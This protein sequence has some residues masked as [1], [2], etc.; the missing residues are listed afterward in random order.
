L[1]P[2]GRIVRLSRECAD[3]LEVSPAEAEGNLFW[4]YFQRKED[5]AAAQAYF[6][7]AKLEAL[8]SRIKETWMTRTHRPIRLE[9]LV[10]KPA[11]DKSGELTHI[12]AVAAPARPRGDEDRQHVLRAIERVAGRLAGHFENLLSEIN[13]YSELVL[14]ELNHASPLRRDVEQIV[15]ASQRAS[16][17][18]QQ[19]ITFSGQRL[20]LLEPVEIDPVLR[21]LE[22]E[23][24]V[25]SDPF[26]PDGP[27]LVLGNPEAL[28][29]MIRALCENAEPGASGAIH[30][31]LA[32]TIIFDTRTTLAGELEPGDYLSLKVSLSK[33]IDPESLAHLFEPFGTSAPAM[34]LATVYGLVRICG[35]GISIIGTPDGRSV[36]EILLPLIRDDSHRIRP[37][38]R[39]TTVQKL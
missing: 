36:I 13:G 9:W 6:E 21:S 15:A 32:Q 26:L 12:V 30:L 39:K 16:D 5:W 29:E 33:S 20:T 17:T 7:R 27:L 8:P 3:V 24:T 23:V 11:W 35:G 37:S 25:D 19:L 34:G 38:A 22:G 18:T 2:E 14:H 10:L 4:E 1:S 31:K 28:G